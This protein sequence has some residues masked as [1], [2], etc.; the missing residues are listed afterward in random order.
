[1]DNCKMQIKELNDCW[2]DSSYF[3]Y[4]DN[5]QYTEGYY[6]PCELIED[7]PQFKNANIIVK[8]PIGNIFE[9]ENSSD[10]IIDI[11]TIEKLKARNETIYWSDDRSCH[12]IFDFKINDTW[13]ENA[14]VDMV[15]THIK[16]YVF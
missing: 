11:D 4:M 12:W 2:G 1:M 6:S 9:I 8:N 7:N 16:F 13:F 3:G 10:K 14:E 15:K 5:K